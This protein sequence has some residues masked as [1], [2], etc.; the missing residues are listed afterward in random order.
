MDELKEV[1]KS[2]CYFFGALCLLFASMTVVSAN[3]EDA[4][5][6]F[7]PMVGENNLITGAA[8]SRT[9]NVSITVANAGPTVE[10]ILV[11]GDP[12]IAAQSVTEDDSGGATALTVT[13]RATD[14]DGIT[15]IDNST[16]NI[17]IIRAAGPG[18][19]NNVSLNS[20]C[21]AE[22]NIDTDTMNFSCTVL[23]HY[24][25]AAAEWNITAGIQDVGGTPSSNT[26]NF[27]LQETTAIVISPG[28]LTF[29]SLNIGDTNQTANND[30]IV[31][32]NTAND[33]IAPDNV[34]VTGL[35]LQGEETTTDTINT[36]NFTVDID[37]GGSPAAECTAATTLVNNTATG[38][39]GS[40]LAAGN[41]TAGFGNES[42]YVCLTEV[43]QGISAQTYSTLN[44]T[45]WTISVV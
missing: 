39:T 37:T 8:S 32:N 5:I 41:R 2:V 42:L 43:P 13:F 35:D 19:E 15:D 29:A 26:S 34:R 16:A 24:W 11:D 22:E 1:K 31:I 17:S 20:S 45:S 40:H 4:F 10:A 6:D 23:I 3:L 18:G 9:T 21:F 28:S 12:T 14:V 25:F 33:G 7:D 27:T 44:G 30:P 38:I 36:G